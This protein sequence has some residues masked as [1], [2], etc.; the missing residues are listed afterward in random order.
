MVFPAVS[1]VN[2]LTDS[3]AAAGCVVQ[4][5]GWQGRKDSN[6]RMP[7]SKS[8]AFTNLA[9]PLLR[10]FMRLALHEHPKNVAGHTSVDRADR[11]DFTRDTSPAMDVHPCCCIHG[12]SSR[13]ERQK[14][15]LPAAVAQTP[16]YQNRS[17]VRG[18]HGPTAIP[19]IAPRRDTVSV[20]PAAGR[21]VRNPEFSEDRRRCGHRY[22]TVLHWCLQQS[23]GV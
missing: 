22:S 6:P 15:P 3:G 14:G 11:P 20:P 12:P 10:T 8:G 2:A 23:L 21:C 1:T 4:K 9:T 16:R 18:D 19:G 7:E 17:S 13:L 5:N